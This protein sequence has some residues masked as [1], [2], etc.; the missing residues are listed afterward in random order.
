LDSGFWA[1]CSFVEVGCDALRDGGLIVGQPFWALYR[2]HPGKRG[3]V[4]VEFALIF[5]LLLAVTF[6][7]LE[8]GRAFANYNLLTYAVRQGARLAAVQPNLQLN[9]NAVLTQI[10]TLLAA[11]GMVPSGRLVQYLPPL[12]ANRIVTVQAQVLHTLLL[13]LP[14]GSPSVLLEAESRVWYEL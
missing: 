7:A 10:D 13:P 8:G 1:L 3:S 14:T 11:G 9:D 12:A 5:P 6:G 4:T 2:K